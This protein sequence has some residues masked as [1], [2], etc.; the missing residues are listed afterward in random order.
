MIMTTP[1]G[2][3][4]KAY[5]V[6]ETWARRCDVTTF[7]YSRDA[8]NIT[9]ARPLDVPEGRNHLT[10]KTMAAL[11]LSFNEQRESIDWFLKGDDDTYII[12]ENLRHYLAQFDPNKPHYVGGRSMDL[13]RNGYNGGG[14]GYLLSH[15]AARLVVERGTEVR[16]PQD[17][18]IEDLDMGRCL[19]KFGIVPKNTHDSQDRY[20][21]HCDHPIKLLAGTGNAP[22][23]YTYSRGNRTFGNP[24]GLRV[25]SP[26]TISFHYMDPAHIFMYDF[27]LYDLHRH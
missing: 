6:R 5:A 3:L 27:L 13:I 18:S 11:R 12:M 4:Q 10:G 15:E 14:A 9:G 23:V 2:W 24:L 21:F 8:G 7:F 16:C 22:S 19:A 17:G 1:G 25:M 20:L 26:E